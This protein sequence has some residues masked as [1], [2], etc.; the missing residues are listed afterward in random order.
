MST[1]ITTSD[2]ARQRAVLGRGL[3]LVPVGDGGV[4]HDLRWDATDGGGRHLRMVEGVENL[5]QDLAVAVLTPLGGDPFD[6]AF[7]FG[8]LSVLTLDI[9]APLAEELLRLSL[10]RTL[11][12]DARVAEVTELVIEPRDPDRPDDRRRVVRATIR[13]VLSDEAR[14]ALGEV[15]LT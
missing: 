2:A 3:A 13:T 10:E 7:G 5:A 15:P 12:A 1:E 8:G 9:S 11:V 6:T 4:A 14:L